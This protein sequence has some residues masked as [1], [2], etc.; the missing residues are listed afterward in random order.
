MSNYEERLLQELRS[1]VEGGRAAVTGA[2]SPP[3]SP[4]AGSQRCWQWQPAL[5]CSPS[6]RGHRLPTP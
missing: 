4:P 5:V 2:P 6:P 3:R 1:V